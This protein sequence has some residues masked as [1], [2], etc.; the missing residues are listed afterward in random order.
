MHFYPTHPPSLRSYDS[1]SDPNTATQTTSNVDDAA[2]RLGNLH[3]SNVDNAA[4]SENVAVADKNANTAP[5]N[6][7]ASGERTTNT[8]SGKVEADG[9]SE[10]TLR[11]L[12]TTKEAGVIIGKGGR[13]V[14]ELREQT[15]VKAGVS[16]VVPGVQDRVLTVSGTLDGVAKVSV[17]TCDIG[18]CEQAM[19]DVLVT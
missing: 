17:D 7:T 6:D 15:G 8:Q 5:N 18:G 13:N 3:L 4:G 11:A 1:M 10:L 9:N 19:R 12:V 2:T 14:A 16:K